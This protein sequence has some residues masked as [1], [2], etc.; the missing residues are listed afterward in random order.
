MDRRT[1]IAEGIAA[2]KPALTRYLKGFDDTNHTRQAPNLPNHAA[3]CLGHLALTMHRVAEKLDGS[4]LPPS[5]FIQGPACT[6]THYATEAISFGSPAPSPTT[7]FPSF[8]RCVEAFNGAVDRLAAAVRNAPDAK[9]DETIKWGPAD[10]PL[11]A[12]ALRMIYHNGTHTGEIADLRR[13]LG[14]GSIFS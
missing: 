7:P 9:L 10:S 5:N 2:T 14:M 8:A 3:W 12:V 4:P 11:W 1:T 13:A 6:S